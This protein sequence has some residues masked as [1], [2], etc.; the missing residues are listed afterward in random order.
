MTLKHYVGLDVLLKEVFIC[1]VD[2]EGAVVAEGKV[3]IGRG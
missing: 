1:V 2:A 3:V